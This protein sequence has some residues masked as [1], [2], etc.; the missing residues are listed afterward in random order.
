[1]RYTNKYDYEWDFLRVKL[2]QDLLYF[3]DRV[4]TKLKNLEK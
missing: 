4:P 2:P 1:M 3:E